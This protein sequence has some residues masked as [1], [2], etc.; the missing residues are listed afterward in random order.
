MAV[1]S[2]VSVYIVASRNI[3]TYDSTKDFGHQQGYYI[4]G[5]KEQGDPGVEK[6][7][8]SDDSVAVSKPL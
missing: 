2:P 5:G 4:L 8:T 7:K 3:G 1:R 6:H